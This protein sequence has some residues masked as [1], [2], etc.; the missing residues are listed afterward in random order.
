MVNVRGIEGGLVT[1]Q[2][3]YVLLKGNTGAPVSYQRTLGVVEQ[4][5][6][7]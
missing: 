4:S 6:P 2:Q 7:W 3:F 5:H 1:N